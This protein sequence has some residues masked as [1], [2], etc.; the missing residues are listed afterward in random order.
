MKP[1]IT[2]TN[3]IN[4]LIN[5]IKADDS[6]FFVNADFRHIKKDQLFDFVFT[7][8]ITIN[9]EVFERNKNK[10]TSMCTTDVNQITQHIAEDGY[11]LMDS[12]YG[13]D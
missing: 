3:K 10:G 4:E 1:A 11:L 9:P 5:Q 8:A 12:D 13:Y 6:I 7:N 2:R